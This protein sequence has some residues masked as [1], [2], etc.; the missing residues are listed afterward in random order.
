[1]LHR[2]HGGMFARIGMIR[3][4]AAGACQSKDEDAADQDHGAAAQ[5]WSCAT[6][7]A[8]WCR[9][10]WRD[11]TSCSRVVVRR[12]IEAVAPVASSWTFHDGFDCLSLLCLGG[13]LQ[14][15]ARTS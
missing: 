4:A 10:V 15:R 2:E 6:F 8:E 9:H 7:A 12:N 3:E 13:P 14:S 11:D 5:N 1:M